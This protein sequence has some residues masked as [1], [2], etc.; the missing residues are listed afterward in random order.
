VAKKKQKQT[1]KQQQDTFCFH[2]KIILG[3]VKPANILILNG[4]AGILNYIVINTNPC[5]TLEEP[6]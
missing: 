2:S 1:N 5:V 6:A 3:D 4:H